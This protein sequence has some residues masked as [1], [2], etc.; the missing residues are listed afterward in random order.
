MRLASAA[1]T[2]CPLGLQTV[3]SVPGAGP[4]AGIEA[5]AGA[6]VTSADFR[7][8]RKLASATGERFA[9]GIVLYDDEISAS[10]GDRLNAVPICALWS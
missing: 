9:A 8:L 6:T 3:R 7:G 4:V 2:S 5:K 10:F 1:R